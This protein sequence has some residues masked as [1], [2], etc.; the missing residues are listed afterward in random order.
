M[1]PVGDAAVR[2]ALDMIEKMVTGAI[3]EWRHRLQLADYFVVD[4]LHPWLNRYRRWQITELGK[5]GVHAQHAVSI[6]LL[7]VT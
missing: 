3:Y 5:F 1:P 7:S 2:Q 4:L 6:Y